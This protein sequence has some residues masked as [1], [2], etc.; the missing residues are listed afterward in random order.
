[1]FSTKL[2]ALHTCS[3]YLVAAV[4]RAGWAPGPVWTVAGDNVG[5]CN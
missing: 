4:Q 3:R 1:V 5:K 2:R